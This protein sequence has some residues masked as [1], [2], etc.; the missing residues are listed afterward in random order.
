MATDKVLNIKTG[1]LEN[2]TVG[3]GCKRHAHNLKDLNSESINTV[4][5]ALDASLEASDTSS[6]ALRIVDKKDPHSENE[7]ARKLW[8]Y[9]GNKDDYAPAWMEYHFNPI[10]VVYIDYL[11]SNEE[12]SGHAKMLLD[13]IYNKYQSSNIDWGEILHPAA[14]YLYEKYSEK[15][16]RSFS[17]EDDEDT[18]W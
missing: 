6:E 15:H 14:S 9:K 16:G 4:V 13:F 10:G 3:V 18:S 7:N 11:K 12:G 17:W 8:L 1:K 5:T 2:C